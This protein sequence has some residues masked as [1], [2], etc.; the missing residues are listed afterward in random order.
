MCTY[1]VLIKYVD[2]PRPNITS[3]GC[4]CETITTGLLKYGSILDI[5]GTLHDAEEDLDLLFDLG[6]GMIFLLDDTFCVKVWI[7]FMLGFSHYRN[8]IYKMFMQKL[9]Q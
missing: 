8:L 3:F 1:T 6:L 9:V 4:G 2:T 5:S 7:D